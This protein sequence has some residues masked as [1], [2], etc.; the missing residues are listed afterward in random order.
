MKMTSNSHQT[1]FESKTEIKVL[2]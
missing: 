2:N 1:T